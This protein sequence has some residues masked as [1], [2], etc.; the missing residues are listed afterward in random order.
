MGCHNMGRY[1]DE[2]IH[3]ICEAMHNI[4][5][6][7]DVIAKGYNQYR[8][9][10]VLLPIKNSIDRLANPK[11]SIKKK[12]VILSK[13]QVGEGVFTALASFVIPALISMITKK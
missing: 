10:H 8:L 5:Y 12:R 2:M 1:P 3:C 13:P 7:A 4:C 9:K 11:Y 6:Y